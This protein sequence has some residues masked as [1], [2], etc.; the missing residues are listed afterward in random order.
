MEKLSLEMEISWQD[1]VNQQGETRVLKIKP[2]GVLLRTWI[3]L[4]LPDVAV[5]GIWYQVHKQYI[6]YYQL[7]QEY[8]FIPSNVGLRMHANDL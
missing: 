5:R 7:Q 1:W 8:V 3:I 6:L 2:L 4:W